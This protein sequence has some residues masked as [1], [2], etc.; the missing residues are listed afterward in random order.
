M[1]AREHSRIKVCCRVRPVGKEAN[2]LDIRQDGSV[3]LTGS[4]STPSTREGGGARDSRRGRDRWGFTFDDVLEE[5]CTQEEVYK[6]C[7]KDIVQSLLRGVHGTILACKYIYF[8]GSGIIWVVSTNIPLE[9]GG[10]K[11]P[12]QVRP[13]TTE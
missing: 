12:F 7:A 1:T 3:L 13:S 4:N 10:L 11:T 5:G 9:R 2:R 6:R 8:V